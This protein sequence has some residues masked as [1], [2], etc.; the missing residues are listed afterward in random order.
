MTAATRVIAPHVILDEDEQVLN[1]AG[2]WQDHILFQLLADRGHS[3][4]V[5]EKDTGQ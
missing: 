3:F 5:S 2:R 1:I 4:D